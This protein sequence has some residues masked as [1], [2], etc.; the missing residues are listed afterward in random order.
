MCALFLKDLHVFL[1]RPWVFSRANGCGARKGPT[2]TP[3][4][5]FG[6]REGSVARALGVLSRE[7]WQVITGLPSG[8][9]DPSK[10]IENPHVSCFAALP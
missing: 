3:R 8:E 10:T 2:C 6:S 7:V 1:R 4:R 9:L 5:K